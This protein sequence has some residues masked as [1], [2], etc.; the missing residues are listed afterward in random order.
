MLEPLGKL[1][2]FSA[3]L[4]KACRCT[5]QLSLHPWA[6][7]HEPGTDMGNEPVSQIL[8]TP[9]RE[10]K[11]TDRCQAES[12]SILLAMSERNNLFGMCK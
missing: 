10:A 2:G 9:C 12:T 1:L 7:Q 5:L 11:M 4:P 8:G 3:L 6:S